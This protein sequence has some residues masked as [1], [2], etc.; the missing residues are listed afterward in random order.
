MTQ[1]PGD[2]SVWLHAVVVSINEG[3][4]P[5]PGGQ[6]VALALAGFHQA[7]A[8]ATFAL[9][10]TVKNSSPSAAAAPTATFPTVSSG[11]IFPPFSLWTTFPCLCQCRL[12]F[13][14]A[15]VSEILPCHKW[16]KVCFRVFSSQFFIPLVTSGG[17]PIST[18]NVLEAAA[19]LY[20]QLQC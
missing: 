17:A 11:A 6:E 16:H 20:S 4:L 12:S 14:S 1:W 15:S 2:I 8:H 9:V 10:R 18:Q 7:V 3:L 13:Q 5:D 19:R